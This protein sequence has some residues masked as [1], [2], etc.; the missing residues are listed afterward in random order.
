MAG[1]A[2]VIEMAQLPSAISNMNRTVEGLRLAGN[3][4]MVD[5]VTETSRSL[6][7]SGAFAFL[8]TPEFQ[9]IFKNIAAN[10][11]SP[12]VRDAL[13]GM[14]VIKVAPDIFDLTN[15][16]I[17]EM[18]DQAIGDQFSAIL[19]ANSST[20]ASQ[21]TEPARQHN[22]LAAVGAF[23]SAAIVKNL[24][25][26]G[27][28]IK[29]YGASS[30]ANSILAESVS[31]LPSLASEIARSVAALSK[32]PRPMSKWLESVDLGIDAWSTLV[33][34]MPPQP[35]PR[36]LGSLSYVGTGSLAIAEA[37]LILAETGFEVEES[38]PDRYVL[39]RERFR[40]NLRELGTDLVLRL[41]GAWER[42]GRPGPDAASQAAHSLVEFIDWTLRLAAPDDDALGWH[43]DNQRP[44]DELSQSGS[45]T[46]ALR[47][48]Y[49]M[50]DRVDEADSAEVYIR[51]LNGL[52]K[53]L[54]KR[55]H[56]KGDMERQAVE[57]LIPG[58]E[59]ILLFI[60]P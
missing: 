58:V 25:P 26:A 15:P 11:L 35:S 31:G 7:S 29:A 3:S 53:S 27:E 10:A 12:V 48:R 6:D 43:R 46:R 52:M 49:L 20:V 36:Q 13:K 21:I 8:R 23:Q 40:A 38:D 59:A 51:S 32:A 55:K 60:L 41:D 45:A 56:A 14:S 44:S 39:L 34:V 24:V 42:V 18:F 54:Q 28:W 47:A 2:K 30:T 4:R 57:R 19:K 22:I 33:S 17:A 37:G 1:V 9:D 5:L 16:K 50:R